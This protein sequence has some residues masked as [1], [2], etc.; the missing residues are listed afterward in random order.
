MGGGGTLTIRTYFE[1]R[2]RKAFVQFQDDGIGIRQE[3]LDHIFE[4]F[5]TTKP[6]GEGTG[7]GLFVSYGI[8]GKY[9]GAIDC[10][11][12]TADSPGKAG[13]TSFTLKLLTKRRGS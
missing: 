1:R 13:G 2:S 12:H 4:P 5:F 9:G 11:S 7:L 10:V 3:D 6:E 8:I